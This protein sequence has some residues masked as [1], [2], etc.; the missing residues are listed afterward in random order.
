AYRRSVLTMWVRVPPKKRANSTISALADLKHAVQAQINADG[1]FSAFRRLPETYGRTA[2]DS[3][4]RRTLDDGKRNY[5]QA[6]GVWRQIEN[7]SPLVLRRFTRQEIWE[8]VYFA[9]CQ[10]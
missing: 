3:V 2:D 8:A 7:S 9:H 5:G 10:N 4:V 1:F 6:N